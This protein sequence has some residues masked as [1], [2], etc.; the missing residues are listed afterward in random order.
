MLEVWKML[1]KVFDGLS[2]HDRFTLHCM[3]VLE[4]SVGVMSEHVLAK[5]LRARQSQT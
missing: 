4:R 1:R 2:V 3:S 5:D